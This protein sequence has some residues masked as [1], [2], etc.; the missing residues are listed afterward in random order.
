MPEG[1]LRDGIFTATH[2]ALCNCY[3]GILGP[4]VPGVG[5]DPAVILVLGLAMRLQDWIISGQPG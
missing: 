2:W 4:C 5:K 3:I 1:D